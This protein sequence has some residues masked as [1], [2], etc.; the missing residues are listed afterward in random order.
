M[1]S[2]FVLSVVALPSEFTTNKHEQS[3]RRS[4]CL[5]HGYSMSYVADLSR[6]LQSKNIMSGYQ[7]L[8]ATA[9]HWEVLSPFT[10]SIGFH[11]AEASGS[12]SLYWPTII[13]DWCL[14]NLNPI[15]Y[16]PLNL[17]TLK[18]YQIYPSS[19]ITSSQKLNPFYFYPNYNLIDTKQPGGS[20]Q[21]KAYIFS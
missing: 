19:N 3:S 14:N 7:K 8:T 16:I 10:E 1:S 5:N 9:S 15:I 21:K 18:L 4:T 17:F 11:E 13:I 20:C 12:R 2:G 6:L